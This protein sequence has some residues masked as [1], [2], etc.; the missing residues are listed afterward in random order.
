VKF[1]IIGF[2]ACIGSLCFYDSN[3]FS[4]QLTPSSALPLQQWCDDLKSGET[5]LASYY[6]QSLPFRV[7]YS[8]EKIS[9]NNTFEIH[10][11][12]K[13]ENLAG[14]A[15]INFQE[16][17]S[18]CLMEADDYL[19]SRDGVQLHLR[20]NFDSR[21][22][23]SGSLKGAE[24]LNRYEEMDLFSPYAVD[25]S[26]FN[27]SGDVLSTAFHW[28]TN[29]SCGTILHESLHL[30]GLVDERPDGCC[31]QRKIGP[32]TSAMYEGYNLKSGKYFRRSC[33]CDEK[34]LN[35]HEC[36]ASLH[37]ATYESIAQKCPENSIQR[38]SVIE[39]SNFQ[40]TYFVDRYE[41]VQDFA[42]KV[43]TFY[44]D[45]QNAIFALIKGK[46]P[47][48]DPPLEPAHARM[49]LYPGC[50][51]KNK[52]Y[53]RAASTA[54]KRNLSFLLFAKEKPY[55]PYECHENPEWLR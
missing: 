31:Q 18:T 45:A 50:K 52:K 23:P 8:I 4:E 37:L 33:S 38:D 2:I 40:H 35:F 21:K 24:R 34:K 42:D 13:I 49:I 5:R 39:R 46:I 9:A 32:L 36:L 17:I 53:L 12:I 3:I 22:R 1:L 47:S 28:D 54:Y 27:Y 48:E 26:P 20:V 29:A 10:I 16:K 44:L 25:G 51:E 7:R 55:D 11:P 6:S 41:D 43:N 19:Y 30:L 14:K 15:L